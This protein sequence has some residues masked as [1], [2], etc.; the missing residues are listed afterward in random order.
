V[1]QPS[2][3]ITCA[4]QNAAL[5]AIRSL[6]RAGWAVLAV[7]EDPAAKGLASRGCSER[8]IAPVAP[9]EDPPA[10]A[11]FIL[12]LLRAREI[13]VLLPV[14]DAAIFALLP[15][16]EEIEKLTAVPWPGADALEAAADKDATFALARELGV[17]APAMVRVAFDDSAFD[18]AALTYPVVIKP[19][20]SLVAG[21]KVAVDYAAGPEELTGLMAALP[22]GAY[23]L[24]LQ[25]R[26]V[27]AGEGYFAVYD[28]G[29]PVLEAA[30]RRGREMPPSGGVSTVREA[31]AVAE[32][33][34]EAARRLLGAWRWH[35][36]AMVEFK[37]GVDGRAYL[38]EVNGRLWGS[39][40]LAIDAGADVPLAA[41]LVAQGKPV[42]QMDY[43]PGFKT[44]WLL[45]DVD[46][47]LTRLLKSDSA[48]KLPPDTPSRAAWLGAFVADFFKP[49]VR[50]ELLRLGDTR[51]FW[52]ELRA[53]AANKARFVK[54]RLL[55]RRHGVR[56]LIHVHSTFSYDGELSI[57]QLAALMREKGV[58]VCC[59][60]E[61]TR[62]LTAERGQRLVAECAEHSGEDLLLVPGL[63]F[64][65]KGWHHI[66][67]L[68]ITEMLP[69]FDY[70]ELVRMIHD[71]GGI[72]VLAHPGAEDIDQDP[73]VARQVDAIEVW[74]AMH[75]GRYLPNAAALEQYCRARRLGARAVAVAGID[76]HYRDN[77]KNVALY[78]DL[79]AGKL[80][81][82]SVREALRNGRF[83]ASN[84][85]VRLP[86]WGYSRWMLPIIGW[87][88][89]AQKMVARLKNR[90]R[91]RTLTP[92][93]EYMDCACG[94][95]GPA[96]D[97]PH[98]ATICW[99]VMGTFSGND[100]RGECCKHIE[101]CSQC[102]YYQYANGT[103]PGE[104]PLRVLHLIETIN[105]GGAELM[106]LGLITS[107]PRD[108]VTSHVVVIKH[109]W[110]EQRLREHNIPVTVMPLKRQLDWRW[111]RDL[112]RL[113]KRR[114]YDVLHSHEF[115]MNAYAFL[116][117]K[118]SGL[119]TQATVHGNLEY[120]QGHWKRRGMY[121]WLT[122][123]AAPL[124]AVSDEIRRMLVEEIG[125]LAEE[126]KVVHNGVPVDEVAQGDCPS[127][128]ELGLPTA[129]R[130]IG[131]VGRLH[132][133]KG[134]DVMIDAMPKLLE[135]A[136]DVR[137]LFFGQG[138]MRPELEQRVAR[139]GL[140]DAVS[141]MGYAENIR[142]VMHCLDLVV[143]PSRYEG[144]SLTLIEAMATELPIVA[145]NVGGT[146]E[147]ITDGEN[148]LLVPVEDPGALA[149][150][151]LRLLTD[152]ELAARLAEQAQRRA[153]ADFGIAE[154]ASAYLALYE[155]K[156]RRDK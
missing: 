45:G 65:Q 66:L 97:E 64:D 23:P 19:H 145:T 131:V 12:D 140:G 72:A 117:G 87:L 91:A 120:L 134:P 34:R 143:V 113:A 59:L 6:H 122:L 31:V 5:A 107:L 123:A 148:G 82:P 47:T 98:G 62:Q 105:P 79:P 25:Q 85:I 57:A 147:A 99:R 94:Q 11:A 109:G 108:K 52:R 30:H 126:I 9:G 10:Y 84:G 27:G 88:R 138:H 22:P 39:L 152:P 50:L 132:P 76:F 101:D 18:P 74:N 16:R 136:P 35:G 3:L 90:R 100:R 24:L 28:H 13:D 102:A 118:L 1:K 61:H 58:Q 96:K 32:D 38:M 51:P 7:D 139:L 43:R 144:L 130:L 129:G 46:A 21:R 42:P 135:A 69:E 54:R 17:P 86:A 115:T 150:A 33:V 137:L 114:E 127:R 154:M 89:A 124:V 121:R 151:C 53:W 112:A 156:V 4:A 14:T 81:W 155:S 48:L 41:A 111:V 70:P 29:E 78:L 106:M 83:F 56:T 80:D 104:R 44:R 103:W 73:E 128:E 133:I 55:P 116:A 36:P 110:L 60:T 15:V 153:V 8:H 77:L 119:P 92:Y 40:Q 37:R 146:P 2:V 20:R 71:R 141:F 49:S 95:E 149:E 67:A 125:L 75:D 93:W 142:D 68:G 63:E 26:I